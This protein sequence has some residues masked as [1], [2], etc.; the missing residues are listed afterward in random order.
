MS[1]CKAYI[2][3][4]SFDI[5]LW[6]LDSQWEEIDHFVN[7]KHLNSVEGN[8]SSP[9]T[10]CLDICIPPLML[11]TAWMFFSFLSS[12]LEQMFSADPNVQS[13]KVCS[14]DLLLT[15]FIAGQNGW[16]QTGFDSSI[17]M[18]SSFSRLLAGFAPSNISI[19]TDSV[20]PQPMQQ[21]CLVGFD[22]TLLQKI[23][24]TESS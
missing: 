9:F 19:F 11:H 8:G 15:K 2:N 24:I 21:F 14:S 22:N 23:R 13:K 6:S 18:Q 12:L 1:L 5:C 16:D 17:P 3:E 4:T 20:W 10:F 7:F